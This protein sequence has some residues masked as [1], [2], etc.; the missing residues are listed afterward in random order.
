MLMRLPGVFVSN[1]KV[2]IRG[3]GSPLFIVDGIEMDEAFIANII[4]ENVNNIGVIKDG[5][6]LSMWGMSGING[7][8]LINTKFGTTGQSAGPG[9]CRFRPIGCL[10]PAEFYMPDYDDPAVLASS[11]T[12]Y[13]STVYWQPI[14]I[15]D[16]TGK[17]IVS[18]FT[19]D[20]PSTYTI[21]VEGLLDNGEAIHQEIRIERN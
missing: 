14:V 5:G 3:G 9:Y 19:A 10:I 7:V 11:E 12:D 20:L 6:R 2:S 1:Q 15:P 4:P 18:F 8:I 13:R 21:T 17:A 16:S